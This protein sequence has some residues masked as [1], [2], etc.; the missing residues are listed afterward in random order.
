MELKKLKSKLYNL[1][2]KYKYVALVLIIGIILMNI[3]IRNS[4]T[5]VQE[6]K[7]TVLP[8]ENVL[9]QADLSN[10]LSQISG[11]GKVQVMLTQRAGSETIYQTNDDITSNAESQSSHFDTVTVADSSK[12]QTGLV[13]QVNPPKYLGVIVVCEGADDP[14]VKLAIVDAVSKATGLNSSCISVLKM[15]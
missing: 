13:K 12:G 2:S 4:N 7:I 1:Y 5:P 15:K 3:P 14:I 11:V 9:I 6:E 8:D 10:I